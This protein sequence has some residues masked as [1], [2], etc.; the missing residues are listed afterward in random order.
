MVPPSFNRK[1]GK[2]SEQ[3]RRQAKRDRKIGKRKG[4]KP[5]K[6]GKAGGDAKPDSRRLPQQPRARFLP[7]SDACGGAAETPAAAAAQEGRRAEKLQKG[8]AQASDQSEQ[9]A[10]ALRLI[11]PWPT[12][13]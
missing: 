9:C 8:R 12:T 2:T 1:K 10:C 13:R 11:V 4:M 5:V 6:A 3:A 7:A